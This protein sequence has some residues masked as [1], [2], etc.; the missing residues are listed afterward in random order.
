MF[1]IKNSDKVQKKDI[2]SSSHDVYDLNV[3][4]LKAAVAPVT[5]FTHVPVAGAGS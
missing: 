1:V 4:D 3:E 2:L 5:G